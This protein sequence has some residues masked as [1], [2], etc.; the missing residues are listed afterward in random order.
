MGLD[1]LPNL[2][3]ADIPRF[4]PELEDGY[5]NR[6]TDAPVTVPIGKESQQTEHVDLA[7]A[8]E[9]ASDLGATF[10]N[11]G[12]QGAEEVK[13]DAPVD[14]AG[15]AV[16]TDEVAEGQPVQGEVK[17]DKVAETPETPQQPV[18]IEP[19][20]VDQVQ[21]QIMFEGNEPQLTTPR[22][23]NTKEG[24][25][26]A[27]AQ[28]KAD[29]IA[30]GR[31]D[32][33][34]VSEDEAQGLAEDYVR[35]QAY[36]EGFY[37]TRTYL[38]KDEYKA[39]ESANK[40]ARKDYYND[41]RAQGVGRR[42]ARRRANEWAQANL[43]HNERLK[44]KDALR[45]IEEHRD[46]FYDADGT[47]SQAKYKQFCE[48][49]M[50][51]HTQP[52]ETRNYYFS[53][54]ERREAAET[55][56]LDDDAVCDM[57]HRASDDKDYNGN[58]RNWE[59]D[60]TEVKQ[61]AK[62]VTATAVVATA[63]ALAIPAVSAGAG[64]AASAGAAAG[65]AAGGA[66]AGAGAG[67]GAG[68]T[69]SGLG[70]LAGVPVA[71]GGSWFRNLF[72]DNGGPEK[73]AYAPGKPKPEPE[74]VIEEDDPIEVCQLTP[75][76]SHEVVQQ[77]VNYCAYPVQRGDNWSKVAQTKYRVQTGTDAEGNPITRPV[78]PA[79]ALKIAHELKM[80]HGIAKRDFN[81]CIFPKVG[82]E[83]R[84]YSEFDGLYHP[85]LAGI[86]FIVDCDAQTDGRMSRGPVR[87][88]YQQWNGQYNGAVREHN[89]DAYWYTDCSNNRSNIFATRPARDAEM[90]RRQAEINAAAGK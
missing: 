50:N 27:I 31:E 25:D 2:R 9:V 74:P 63:G 37:S 43:V 1:R 82:E 11:K 24:R 30:H 47:F 23:L 40:Q 54:K 83:L 62:I 13:T 15:A 73:A 81:K 46:Q 65:G 72:R 69:I 48:G 56:H 51:T 17:T 86:K 53:L 19:Q 39:A 67:A 20:T 6:Q 52:G 55:L 7:P 10:S 71:V 66:A 59:K 57:V 87:G 64:A 8:D 76:E 38:T 18:K 61:I 79:E 28:A 14:G 84:L 16:K 5:T 3:G 80:A 60:Y 90:Q 88:Q 34:A 29:F 26:A 12:Q 22:T 68:V 70:A 58:G 4:A 44:N 41:L 42:E 21:E 75:D 36:R 85:E 89:I 49:L 32:G 35:N 33:T 45:Y 78:T 77:E